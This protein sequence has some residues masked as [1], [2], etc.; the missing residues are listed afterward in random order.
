M[1]SIIRLPSYRD[2]RGRLTVI[3]GLLPFAIARVY[4]VYA[5]TDKPRGGHRHRKTVQA[6]VSVAGSCV[7]DWTNGFQKGVETLNAPDKL[8]LVQ[9]ED[10]HVM[11]DFSADSV[12]LVLAS[13]PFDASDYID[14]EYDS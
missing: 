9:P 10:W 3:D 1:A 7:V 14:E 6:L 5:A 8:L 13:E 4:Y 11:R 12:L 2:Q